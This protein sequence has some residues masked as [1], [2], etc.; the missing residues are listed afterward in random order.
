MKDFLINLGRYPAYLISVS[1]GIFFA[2][3]GWLKPLFKNRVTTVATVGIFTGFLAF[4]FFTLQ[5]ML[6]LSAG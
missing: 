6:G 4:I 5:A 1:L 2:L 3:F